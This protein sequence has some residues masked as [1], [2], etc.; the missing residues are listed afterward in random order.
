MD[1]GS[2]FHLQVLKNTKYIKASSNLYIECKMHCNQ[3][4]CGD[5]SG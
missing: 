4:E 1:R 3:R 2:P 5:A